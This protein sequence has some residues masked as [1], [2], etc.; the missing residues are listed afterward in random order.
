LKR[1]RLLAHLTAHGCVLIREGAKHS[2]WEI[3]PMAGELPCRDTQKLATSWRERFAEIW[4]FLKSNAL[5][6][7]S[8]L[9]LLRLLLFF[10]AA[11]VAEIAF[12]HFAGGFGEALTFDGFGGFLSGLFDFALHFH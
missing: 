2:W 8:D 9:L 3:L 7:P 1:R 12:D 11:Q 6:S 5:S 4:A 10:L